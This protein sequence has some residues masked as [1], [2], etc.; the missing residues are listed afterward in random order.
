MKV[1]VIKRYAGHHMRKIYYLR[2]RFVRFASCL[3]FTLLLCA[4]FIWY[5]WN[6]FGNL[7]NNLI[8]LIICGTLSI[9]FILLFIYNHMT[10]SM[11]KWIKYGK[12]F[13]LQLLFLLGIL[14]LLKYK[15]IASNDTLQQSVLVVFKLLISFNG[16]AIF[17]I[18]II[19]VLNVNKKIMSINTKRN[20]SSYNGIKLAILGI[21]FLAHL[22]YVETVLTSNLFYISF[23]IFL[24]S[25]GIVLV[26]SYFPYDMN[27][28][29]EAVS[30]EFLNLHMKDLLHNKIYLNESI[31]EFKAYRIF[32]IDLNGLFPKG[33]LNKEVKIVNQP[34]VCFEK[35]YDSI[36]EGTSCYLAVSDNG[37]ERL[38]KLQVL[39]MYR[40]R[41]NKKSK[42]FLL[43]FYI[44]YV[45][46]K[47]EIIIVDKYVDGYK[48]VLSSTVNQDFEYWKK[49]KFDFKK[50]YKKCYQ[51]P[52][53]LDLF[54]NKLLLKEIT[55][56]RKWV[57]HEGGYGVGK[58][59]L[60]VLTVSNTGFKPVVVSPWAENYDQDILSL[61]FKNVAEN[62]NR[63]FYFPDRSVMMFYF[64]ELVTLVPTFYFILTYLKIH[65]IS[66][67]FADIIKNI[68]QF[69]NYGPLFISSASV[70]LAIATASFFLPHLILLRKN[71]TKLYQTFYLKEIRKTL[72]R[73]KMVFIVEDVDRL[74]KMALEDTVRTLS[75]LNDM[76]YH[77]KRIIGIISYSKS[78]I[79]SLVNEGVHNDILEDIENKIIYEDIF[80]DYSNQETMRTYLKAS[81]FS[82]VYQNEKEDKFSC[83]H[84]LKQEIDRMSFKNDNLR[85]IH[86]FLDDISEKETLNEH[87]II[88]L[89]KDKF[90]KES[91]LYTRLKDSFLEK[92]GFHYE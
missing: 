19:N 34:F 27:D 54:Q 71:S 80:K 43:S 47:G 58:T 11:V 41:D 74:N 68:N 39:L 37:V 44:K 9:E 57:H 38:A 3:I 59:S 61:V 6:G 33:A 60:D 64:L 25:F 14:V 13:L 4:C 15:P 91:N 52:Q 1:E 51:Y 67:F 12:L 76:C 48:K 22:S 46:I 92:M 40:D 65:L 70:I 75:T 81:L 89:L 29:A 24:L 2:D 23:K 8:V 17:F 20:L 85:D 16:I 30:I 87:Q 5:K 73:E 63:S 10:I 32:K 55:E 49:N 18:A 83:Y 88:E 84:K 31:L 77:V 7:D 78:N 69:H 72:L 79:A 62:S 45:N 86:K 90:K 53:G 36:E 21:V 42:K 56:N 26:I 35:N 82:I 66:V 28:L 50:I